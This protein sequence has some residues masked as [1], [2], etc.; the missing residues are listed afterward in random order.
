MNKIEQERK[1]KQK[2]YNLPTKK[3]L[4]LD[5][6]TAEFLKNLKAE[7]QPLVLQL[8][9]EKKWK[10]GTQSLSMNDITLIPKSGKDS[11]KREK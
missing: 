11:T 9:T 6:I 8:F 10:E 2:L 1:F 4:F 7:L 5:G 3:S